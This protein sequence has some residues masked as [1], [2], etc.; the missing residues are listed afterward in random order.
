MNE[1]TIWKDRKRTLF[2]LPWSFTRYTLT[3][4]KLLIDTGF[5]NRNEEEVRLYR[6][7]D[8]TLNRTFGQRLF[9]L[10]TVHCNSADKTTPVFDIT[11]VKKPKEVKNLLS[12]LVEEERQRRRVGMREFVG[13]DADA[14]G[15]GIDDD[16]EN[17]DN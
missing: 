4:T 17:S 1:K 13:D 2:G 6:I 5:F 12:D 3:E 8:V 9:G 10:G 16:D 11:R 7:L 15:D 14:D